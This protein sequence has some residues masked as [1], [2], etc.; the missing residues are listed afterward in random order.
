MPRWVPALRLPAERRPQMLA[1][2]LALDPQD[3]YLRFG[4]AAS[5]EQIERYVQGID[6]ER[7]DLFGVFNRRLELVALVHLAYETGESPNEA[8]FGISVSAH[9]RGK[10]FGKRLFE[11]AMLLAR[12]KGVSLLRIHALAENKPMLHIARACGATVERHGADAEALLRL[13]EADTVSRLE[14]WLESHAA[15]I[16]F[17]VKQQVQRIEKV[18]SALAG[19]N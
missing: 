8:E 16:D 5:D 3:R 19:H 4:Y 6:L 13:P 11:H 15:E 12:N 7:D 2:L 18:R 1:H 14:E 9:L 17:T 10:G